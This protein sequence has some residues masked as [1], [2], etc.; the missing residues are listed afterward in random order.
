MSAA[1][2]LRPFGNGSLERLMHKISL[3]VRDVLQ[4]VAKVV[5]F[6]A[7]AV[8]VIAPLGLI[9]FG[10]AAIAFAC[11][12]LWVSLD[13]MEDPENISLPPK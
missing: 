3:Q 13:G 12:V 1:L 7:G 9:L 10:S 5:G 8:A 6:L 11:F 4:K 2:W